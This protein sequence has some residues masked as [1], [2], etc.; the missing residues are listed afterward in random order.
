MITNHRT[1]YHPI[2]NH[3]DHLA[4]TSLTTRPASII[5]LTIQ[6]PHLSV[7][8]LEESQSQITI[9]LKFFP[10][11]YLFTFPK[12][13]S[14]KFSG[15][16]TH[17]SLCVEFGSILKKHV[18]PVVLEDIFAFR[19]GESYI[20]QNND[21][22]DNNNSSF[23]GKTAR[24]KNDDNENIERKKNHNKMEEKILSELFSELSSDNDDDGDDDYGMEHENQLVYKGINE[25]MFQCY[26][27]LGW[28]SG[29]QI[30]REFKR[31]KLD[32]ESW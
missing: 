1:C 26:K 24:N 30:E 23:T 13:N 12:S 17:Q 18:N 27:K 22:D 2:R 32:N 3:S 7:S 20:S 11:R 5:S 6:I 25:E 14:T 15:N 29:Y 9:S 4:S 28:T 19:M 16:I 8:S 21:F 31:L 10:F